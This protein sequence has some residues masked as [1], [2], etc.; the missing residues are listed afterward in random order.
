LAIKVS[1]SNYPHRIRRVRALVNVDTKEREMEF[2][3]N[4]MEWSQ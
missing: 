3:T 4:N 2:L 1:Y